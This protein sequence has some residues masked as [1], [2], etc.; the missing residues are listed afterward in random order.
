MRDYIFSLF[1]VYRKHIWYHMS[2]EPSCLSLERNA[3]LKKNCVA[4]FV[5][6]PLKNKLF[7]SILLTEWG[8]V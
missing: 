6:I 7:F 5:I 8:L 2:F 4:I 1:T 3:F